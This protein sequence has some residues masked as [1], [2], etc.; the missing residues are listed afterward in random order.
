MKNRVGFFLVIST[1]M[2]GCAGS[3][4]KYDSES[5][6][7]GFIKV[8]LGSKE[9]VHVSDKIF[10]LERKCIETPKVPIC[11][12]DPIGTLTVKEVKESYSVVE[13]DKD[14]IFK[15]GYYFKFAM[16]CEDNA[17]KCKAEGVEESKFQKSGR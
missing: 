15:E 12:F 9:N 11:K 4:V 7:S 14:I 17:E 13:P 5:A 2:V 1:F 8:A 16:H 3:V 6:K 10:L